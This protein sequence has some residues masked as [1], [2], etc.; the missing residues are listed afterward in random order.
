MAQVRQIAA[1]TNLFVILVLPRRYASARQRTAADNKSSPSYSE[2]R[3]RRPRATEARSE[4]C[5]TPY[6]GGASIPAIW[7]RSP[8]RSRTRQGRTLDLGSGEQIIAGTRHGPLTSL[9][10]ATAPSGTISEAVDFVRSASTSR[11]DSRNGLSACDFLRECR[12]LPRLGT[13]ECSV[14]Q[15]LILRAFFRSC[16]ASRRPQGAT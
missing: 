16:C 8:A 13:R 2:R 10:V 7:L 15:V 1:N 14:G 12:S 5:A 6:I 4:R 9:K 11:I 3:C